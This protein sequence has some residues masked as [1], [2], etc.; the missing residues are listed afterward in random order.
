MKVLYP[1]PPLEKFF[2]HISTKEKVGFPIKT[3]LSTT[4]LE[5]K[6]VIVNQSQT[7]QRKVSN[8]NLGSKGHWLATKLFASGLLMLLISNSSCKCCLKTITK[9]IN[10][11]T[12]FTK[13]VL[14]YIFHQQAVHFLLSLTT[15]KMISHRSICVSPFRV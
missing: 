13:L 7:Y 11:V 9:T 6:H 3:H 14:I 2:Y 15:L 5:F 12:K 1:L 4:G 8:L 10:H